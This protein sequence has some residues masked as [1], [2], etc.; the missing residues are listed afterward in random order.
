MSALSP[1][2][3]RATVRGVPDQDVLLVTGTSDP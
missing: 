1:G 2:L 3:Y